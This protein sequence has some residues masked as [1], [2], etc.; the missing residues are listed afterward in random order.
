MISWYQLRDNTKISLEVDTYWAWNAGVEPIALITENAE[1]IRMIHL[2]D[3]LLGG[4]GRSLGSGAAPVREVLA[5]ARR[6]SMLP[7]VESE[8]LDPTG[9]EE[10]QRCMDFLKSVEA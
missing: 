3:G 6:L 2:K 10:V 8:G 9:R 7:V 4:Q 5:A 1:R